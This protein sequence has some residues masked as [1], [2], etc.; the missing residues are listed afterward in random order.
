MRLFLLP[1]SKR[2]TLIHC[3]RI[4]ETLAA[5]AKPPFI[6]RITRTA[7]ES[8][9][10]WEK[11]PKGW[12]KQLTVWGNK[13]CQRIPYEE[14]GLKTV[15]PA[16][17]KR[18]KDVDE[19]KPKFTCLYPGHFLDSAKVDAVVKQLALERQAFHRRKMWQSVIMAPLM[20]PFAL[21][22]CVP[23]L[24]L[25]YMLFRAWSHYRAWYGGKFL[26]YLTSNKLIDMVSS[27]E[28]DEIYAAGLLYPNREASRAAPCPTLEETQRA[29]DVTASRTHGGERD[30][31]VLRRW[32]GKLIAEAFGLPEM[33]LEVERAVDQVEQVNQGED[34]FANGSPL[35]SDV[36]E[37]G[38]V[39]RIIA[40]ERH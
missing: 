2:R 35:I 5:G 37:H 21:I 11:K 8:W 32:N 3:E 10:T 39:G 31:M 19:G 40:S 13:I 25:G 22:P 4:Q 28:M 23:N 36:K 12:Q 26:E 27:K 15:P 17:K 1:V 18:L 24:P 9:V 20:L 16:T 33:E 30:V 34:E 6:D 14:W 7:S 38:R 29:A